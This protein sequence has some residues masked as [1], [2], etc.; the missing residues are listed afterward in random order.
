MIGMTK[1]L[2]DGSVLGS[3]NLWYC[4]EWCG[5]GLHPAMDVHVHVDGGGG[6]GG[7]AMFLCWRAAAAVG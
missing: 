7:D 6:G 2:C 5:I 4:S 1:Y 3:S